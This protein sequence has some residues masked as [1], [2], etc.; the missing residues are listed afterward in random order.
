[1]KTIAHLS[2]LHFGRH[3]PRVA[4]A[5]LQD[6]REIA[7]SLVAISGDLT[8]RAR[9]KEFQAARDFLRQV[10]APRISVPGNHDIPLENLFLRLTDPFGGY[11]KYIS[12]ETAP[13]FIDPEFALFGL[14][15]VRPSHWKRG[16]FSPERLQSLEARID[17]APPRD[18]KIVLC[19]HPIVSLQKLSPTAEVSNPERL[20]PLLET[21][22]VDLVLAGH[23][24]RQSLAETIS[25]DLG[26]KHSTLLVQAGTALSTRERGE[27]NAYTVITLR[28]GEIS[29]TVRIWEGRQFTPSAATIYRRAD[30]MWLLA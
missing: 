8:Q 25:M 24:H 22:A 10:P 16:Y 7:P 19:H 27:A 15:T 28:K 20:L 2:D 12:E 29:I 13:T 23:F 21:G 4:E 1:M 9:K 26:M 17:A 6:L 14:N 3:S 18:F 30:K 11:R 5:I